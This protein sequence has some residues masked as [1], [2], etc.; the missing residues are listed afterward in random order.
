MSLQRYWAAFVQRGNPN[1]KG[2]PSWPVFA[3]IHAAALRFTAS[4]MQHLKDA[5]LAV[6]AGVD[7]L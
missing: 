2:L 4:G 3:P 7:L 1:A 6:C 5:R